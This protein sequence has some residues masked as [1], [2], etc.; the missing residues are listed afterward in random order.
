MERNVGRMV[1]LTYR[2][3]RLNRVRTIFKATGK[4]I[5]EVCCYAAK[6]MIE[7]RKVIASE[8]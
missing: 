7:M 1:S 4:E 3:N 5:C 8:K 2:T 6:G